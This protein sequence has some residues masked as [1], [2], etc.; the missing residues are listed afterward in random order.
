VLGDIVELQPTQ[1]AVRLPI[2]ESLVKRAGRMCREI[3]EDESDPLGFRK[4]NVG[5]IAQE[6]PRSPQRFGGRCQ[7]RC[8]SRKTNGLTVPLRLYS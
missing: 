1:D 4:V 6:G 5:D 3:V 2:W 7:S 8:V